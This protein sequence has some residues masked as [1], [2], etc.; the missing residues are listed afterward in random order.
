MYLDQIEVVST[1]PTLGSLFK[2]QNNSAWTPVQS[3]DMK[4]KLH[5]AKV[6]PIDWDFNFG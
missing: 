5:K 3:E 2:S 1:Q 6:H 4:V